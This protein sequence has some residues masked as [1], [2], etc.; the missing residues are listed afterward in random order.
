MNKEYK[1]LPF[2]CYRAVNSCFCI[3]L[4]LAFLLIM[5]H[6]NAEQRQDE[7][8]TCDWIVLGVVIFLWGNFQRHLGKLLLKT[9][10][11]KIS[12][13]VNFCFPA[14]LCYEIQTSSLISL[15]YLVKLLM[16]VC[17]GPIGRTVSHINTSLSHPPPVLFT[18]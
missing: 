8:E 12:V 17:Q 10:M 18:I 11:S 7:E 9:D 3:M 16:C 6:I 1:P 5:L 14:Q 4:K 2:N 15:I 13:L